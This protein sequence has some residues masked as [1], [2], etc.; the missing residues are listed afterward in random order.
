MEYYLTPAALR[1]LEKLPHDIRKRI[2]HK[3]NFYTRQPAPLIFAR[4]LTNEVAG[5]FR[6]R[7]GDYRIIFN[8]VKNK[9]I[10]HAIG[11]RRD[12]YKK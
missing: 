3:L 6:L 10:V 5:K 11:H 1:D 4:Q 12:I 7:V 2:Y 8:V 9:M